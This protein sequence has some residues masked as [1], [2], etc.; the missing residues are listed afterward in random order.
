MATLMKRGKPSMVPHL[1]EATSRNGEF[2]FPQQFHRR[3]ISPRGA[4]SCSKPSPVVWPS[5]NTGTSVEAERFSERKSA[6]RNPT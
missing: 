6:P 5:L 3:L 4:V 1:I 2:I